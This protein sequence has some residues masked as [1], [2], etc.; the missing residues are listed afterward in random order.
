MVRGCQPT[1]A[2]NPR[3]QTPTPGESKLAGTAAG[4]LRDNARANAELVLNLAHAAE[5]LQSIRKAYSRACLDPG[6]DESKGED[7]TN[8]AS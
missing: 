8:S 1:M 2:G 4:G 6:N 7:A 5:S 3:R